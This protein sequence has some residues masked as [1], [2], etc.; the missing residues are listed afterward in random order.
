MMHRS[1]PMS[2]P[3][4]EVEGLAK[5]F[6]MH[7]LHQR[8]PAFE[9]VSFRL[10]PGRFLLLRGHNGAGKSTL[11]RTLYRTYLPKGGHIWLNTA[12][13]RIDLAT[14]ADVDVALLRRREIG[15]VT[16]FLIARPRVAAEEIVAEPLRLAGRPAAEALEAARAALAE[17]GVKRELWAAYPSTFSGGEQQKVNLARALILPQRL[18]ML[19]EP[20]AS[21]D[22]DT[23]DWIRTY[24]ET[25]RRE[26]G[27]T[28]LLASHNMPEVERLCS[29][30]LMMRKGSIVDRGTPTELLERY[31]RDTMEDVFLDIARERRTGGVADAAAD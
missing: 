9:G 13:G 12:E 21:L 25:Y 8:L 16:Q 17:F 4:L 6:D 18:L 30:V 27:A 11:L 24:L 29:L 15:F 1:L 2:L 31:G 10:Y 20:T 22:P 19:D 28:I 3:V 23:A 7:H 5:H 26:T 14:A